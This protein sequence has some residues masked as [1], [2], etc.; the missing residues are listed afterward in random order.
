MS[1]VK[2]FLGWGC[3][4]FLDD[5]DDADVPCVAS[6]LAA[7][8]GET[9]RSKSSMSSASSAMVKVSSKV[10]DAANDGICS[11]GKDGVVLEV[12]HSKEDGIKDQP[13]P[14]DSKC[15]SMGRLA[16]GVS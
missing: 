3:G 14:N 1:S 12:L 5:E 8:C 4:C 9:G 15:K 2:A 11:R 10:S 7:G 16:A 13:W 6:L